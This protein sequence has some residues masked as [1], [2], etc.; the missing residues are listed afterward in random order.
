APW[1]ALGLALSAA[2][3]MELSRWLLKRFGALASSGGKAAA[4]AFWADGWASINTWLAASLLT[5]GVT[6]VIGLLRGVLLL[7]ASAVS[8]LLLPGVHAARRAERPAPPALIR[9][10]ERRKEAGE[11]V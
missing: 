10:L 8:A 2:G 3:N 7:L 6:M 5:A 9:L 4:A 11:S 1:V